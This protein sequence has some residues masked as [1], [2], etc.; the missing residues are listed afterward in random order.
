MFTRL[1]FTLSSSILS[2]LLLTGDWNLLMMRSE[3]KI[4]TKISN[5][6][7]DQNSQM[8]TLTP[9]QIT[10]VDKWSK[11]DLKVIIYLFVD[12]LFFLSCLLLLLLFFSLSFR[13]HVSR[14]V[15]SQPTFWPLAPHVIVFF[16]LPLIY[17]YSNCN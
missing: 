15:H 1:R 2:L 6:K 3:S 8:M 12:F 10:I 4:A 13:M 9:L 7:N 11:T 16:L 17:S 14:L 5:F